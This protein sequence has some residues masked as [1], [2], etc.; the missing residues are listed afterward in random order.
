MKELNT[1]QTESLASRLILSQEEKVKLLEDKI[2]RAEAEVR[3]L[4]EIN[5]V[6]KRK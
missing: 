2:K 4:L 6:L 1:T 3:A 5:K